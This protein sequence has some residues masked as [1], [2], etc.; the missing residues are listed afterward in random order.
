MVSGGELMMGLI[1]AQ[2]TDNTQVDADVVD[3][4]QL[5]CQTLDF[6]FFGGFADADI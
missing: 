4:W 2:Q 6:C 1:A 3:I 5:V